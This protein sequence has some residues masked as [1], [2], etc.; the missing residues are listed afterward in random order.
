MHTCIPPFKGLC[1]SIW[2]APESTS[3]GAA[4]VGRPS[5]WVILTCELTHEG[6]VTENTEGHKKVNSHSPVSQSARAQK[7]EKDKNKSAK[8]TL[9][10]SKDYTDLVYC[11]MHLRS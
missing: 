1:A 9:A 3:K 2:N 6:T 4:R 11:Y 10:T 7:T 8:F 5:Y